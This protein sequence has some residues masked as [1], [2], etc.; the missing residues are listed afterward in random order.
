MLLEIEMKT[1]IRVQFL[2]HL[3]MIFLCEKK[4]DAQY[5]LRKYGKLIF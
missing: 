4:I 5:R 2:Q 1:R 3:F